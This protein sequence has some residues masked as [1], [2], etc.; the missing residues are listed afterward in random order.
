MNIQ[1]S[2]HEAEKELHVLKNPRLEAEVLL[3]AVLHCDRVFL[4]SHPKKK[5]SWW[6]FL[7]YKKFVQKRKRKIPIAYIIGYKNWGG[8]RVLVNKQTLI[9][10]DE[11]EVLCSH[12]EGHKRLF[13]PRSLLDIGTGSGC[14]A[15]Y[16]GH[17][18]PKAN[19]IALDNSVLA[20]RVARK[21][22]RRFSGR[23]CVISSDLLEKISPHSMFDI[24]VANLPY[25]PQGADVTSEIGKEP[26]KAIF[27]GK[28]GLDVVRALATQLQEKEILFRELWLEFL[29]SQ[30]EAIQRIFSSYK[31]VFFPD[32]GGSIFFALVQRQ[33]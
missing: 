29:P 16:L 12:I 13:L 6:R 30:K 32:C 28:D 2:L 19:V 1:N 33:A 7:L 23:V 10:R 3:C 14:I 20:L 17:K 5:V 11:T 21:N 24:I 9:P 8:M 4:K 31:V 15:M 18:Y 26:Y 27:G 22:L 25:V